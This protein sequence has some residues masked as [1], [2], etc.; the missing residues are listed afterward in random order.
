[1]RFIVMNNLLRTDVPLHRRYDL[2]GSTLGRTAGPESKASAILKDLD[3][4]MRLQLAPE[5]YH[6]CAGRC[7]CPL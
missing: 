1:M 3:V 5:W 7:C 2:K 6:R 4:D